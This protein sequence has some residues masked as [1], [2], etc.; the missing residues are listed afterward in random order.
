M[1]MWYNPKKRA[2]PHRKGRDRE[3][4]PMKPHAE[5]VAALIF[6][7]EK[8]LICRRP[9][10][11]ARG[12]LWE[13]AGGKVEAGET[14]E[15]ALVRECREELGVTPKV[16]ALYMELEHDYEDLNVRLCLFRCTVSEEPQKLEHSELKW[17]AR[18]EIPQYQFCPADE[19]ILAR[20]MRE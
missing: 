16:G 2:E 4:E 1:K 5:V 7:G 15:Q 20:L 9:A 11:K 19:E 14:R 18:G 8:F 12:G 10:G 13:F 3:G 17:I 6:R